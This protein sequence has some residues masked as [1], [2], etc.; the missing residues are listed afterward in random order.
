MTIQEAIKFIEEKITD[1][2]TGLDEE[3]FL[4]ITRITPMV[5]VDLLIK[6]EKNRTLLSWRDD[7][8]HGKGWHLPGGII[9][10]KEKLKNRVQKVAE[11][12]IRT[13]IRFNPD[14]IAINEIIDP[15]HKTRGH[16]IS[17]LYQCFLSQK[18]EPKNTGLTDTDPGYLLWH[19]SCPVNMIKAHKIYKRYIKE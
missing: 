17:I 7:P 11:Q 5:N 15:K 4:F 16:F 8:I 1:P 18:Y 3:L 14:P 2:K 13:K 6:D 19:D 10:Y 12:E 9:R